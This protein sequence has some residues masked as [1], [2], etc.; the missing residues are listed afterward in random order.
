MLHFRDLRLENLALAEML[1]KGNI[2]SYS[3][4]IALTGTADRASYQLLSVVTTWLS[5]V[6]VSLNWRVG[7][8]VIIVHVN[9]AHGLALARRRAWRPFARWKL[10]TR[11][12]LT[13]WVSDRRPS[14]HQSFYLCL[15]VV[16]CRIMCVGAGHAASRRLVPSIPR[17]ELGFTNAAAVTGNVRH[18]RSF[19]H[20]S[21]HTFCSISLRCW[22]QTSC[23]MY[24][25]Y[26]KY[27]LS[28]IMKR[29]SRRKYFDW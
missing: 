22:I 24:K 7:R 1:H 26:E 8:W 15:F 21:H 6:L 3:L 13:I 25:I 17:A 9:A 10:T 29:K 12:G 16:L 27:V 14:R 20:N 23:C 2:R 11:R 19:L 18:F 28:W 4:M 5:Y